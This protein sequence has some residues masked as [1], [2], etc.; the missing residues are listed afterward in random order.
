M[1]RE[2]RDIVRGLI[3]TLKP[4]HK[5]VSKGFKDYTKAEAIA[6]FGETHNWQEV[7]RIPIDLE[8]ETKTDKQIYEELNKIFD[9]YSRKGVESPKMEKHRVTQLNNT[10]HR[11]VQKHNKQ[12]LEAFVRYPEYYLYETAEKFYSTGEG[13]ADYILERV[14]YTVFTV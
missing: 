13:L 4:L 7:N 8:K 10:V 12:Y 11:Y 2:Q 6:Q 9:F 5:K 3:K 1:N 14:R